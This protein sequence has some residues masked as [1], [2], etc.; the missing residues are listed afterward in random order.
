MARSITYEHKNI[1]YRPIGKKW[2]FMAP[3]YSFIYAAHGQENARKIAAQVAG[4]L[5]RT[6]GAGL[7]NL[8]RKTIRTIAPL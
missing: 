5:A 8:A 7:D 1:Q 2:E 4:G 6:K 3:N